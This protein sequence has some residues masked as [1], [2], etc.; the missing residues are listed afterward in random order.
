MRNLKIVILAFVSAALI[1]LS[2][3]FVSNDVFAFSKPGAVTEVRFDCEDAFSAGKKLRDNGIIAF[4]RLYGLYC[5]MKGDGRFTVAGT[6]A[7]SSDMSYDELRRTLCTEKKRQTEV[8]VTIPEGSTSSDIIR[9]LTAAGIGTEEGFFAAMN[10][11]DYDFEFVKA[12]SSLPAER[13]KN[14]KVTLEGYLFP[15]TYFFSAEGSERQAVE[16]MLKNFDEKFNERYRASC[17][18][19]GMSI[20]DAVTL[21]SIV[22][23]EARHREDF[24]KVASV[25]RNRL[26][27]RRL[28]KLE[29]DATSVYAAGRPVTADDLHSDDP[30]NTYRYEGLPPG[31]ICNPG[32]RA[33]LAA[34]EPAE[35]EYYY[36][37]SDRNGNMYYSKTKSEH[38]GY[39]EMIKAVSAEPA[40]RTG[41]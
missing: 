27:S 22:E 18:A 2:A 3:V 5:R 19:Q 26:R 20:D 32:K 28:K 4:P 36:F 6:Y 11:V 41:K 24:K 37:V 23:K 33:L 34:L 14:R 1:S 25:F 10:C 13:M 38:D 15:D 8:A 29:S 12:L 39:V 21:A 35:T 30:Y 40:P 7:L 9:L 31:A 17:A 16:K